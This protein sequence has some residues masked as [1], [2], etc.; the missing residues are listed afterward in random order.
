MGRSQHPERDGS[1]VLAVGL[2]ASGEQVGV[3]H[4]H[5]LS[6]V[7]VISIDERDRVDVTR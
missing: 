3:A 5:I 4:G 1:E 7:I 6:I 2:E